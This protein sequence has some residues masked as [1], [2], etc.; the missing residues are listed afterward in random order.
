MGHAADGVVEW[1]GMLLDGWKP[2]ERCPLMSRR[3]RR[4]GTGGPSIGRAHLQTPRAATAHTPAE[5][6]SDR[7]KYPAAKS[8]VP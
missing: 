1:D 4:R 5:S 3:E 8:F 7:P 2:L 6:R